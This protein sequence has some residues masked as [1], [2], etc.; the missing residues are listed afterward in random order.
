MMRRI[1]AVSVIVALLAVPLALVARGYACA[2]QNCTMM[3][4]L[5]SGGHPAHAMNMDCQH[6]SSG[7]S[8]CMMRCSSRGKAVDYGLAS[9]IAPTQLAEGFAIPALKVA[10]LSLFPLRDMTSAGF[11]FEPF[12]PPRA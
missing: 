5:S 4:C 3:C 2:P 9:P 7:A 11:T 10:R 1:Q 8:A 12:Q 6:S